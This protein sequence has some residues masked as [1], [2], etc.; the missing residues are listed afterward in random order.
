MRNRA[1]AMGALLSNVNGAA[2]NPAMTSSAENEK[3]ASSPPGLRART[4]ATATASRTVHSRGLRF[5]AL[6]TSLS[7]SAYPE[8][9]LNTKMQAKSACVGLRKALGCAISRSDGVDACCIRARCCDAGIHESASAA[10]GSAAMAVIP[11][12][13]GRMPIACS[14]KLLATMPNAAAIAVCRGVGKRQMASP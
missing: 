10:R 9:M 12:S 14:S 11:A 3:S 13:S 5:G 7:V 6:S 2:R 4:I 8:A 1:F